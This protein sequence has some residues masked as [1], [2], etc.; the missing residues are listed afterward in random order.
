MLII[1]FLISIITRPKPPATTRTTPL[2][3]QS[4][5]TATSPARMADTTI[6]N[7]QKCAF[8][9]YVIVV[10]CLSRRICRNELWSLLYRW[11][12]LLDGWYGSFW[13]LT[14]LLEDLWENATQQN[15]VLHHCIVSLHRHVWRRPN[16]LSMHPPISIVKPS[17][18][19][20]SPIY[21]ATSM[22]ILF[23]MRPTWSSS[24]IYLL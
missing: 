15:K 1:P 24:F 23:I 16:S 12:V 14:N 9:S 8:Y 4:A 20:Y 7:A 13:I 6:R 19:D 11:S 21:W 10:V 17:A 2:S 3:P 22:L 18:L 5:C